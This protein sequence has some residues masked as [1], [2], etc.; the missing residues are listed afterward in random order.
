M[1]TSRLNFAVKRSLQSAGIHMLL[2][3]SRF[4]PD[5]TAATNN[6]SRHSPLRLLNVMSIDAC[7]LWKIQ[8]IKIRQP[9]CFK[10]HKKAW[11]ANAAG[12][13]LFFFTFSLIVSIQTFHRVACVRIIAAWLINS[14]SDRDRWRCGL[15]VYLKWQSKWY[16]RVNYEASKQL[17]D[18]IF[19]RESPEISEIIYFHWPLNLIWCSHRQRK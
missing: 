9:K 4:P 19:E 5:R 2:E 8:E 14:D 7:Y 15:G 6:R 13:R 11:M 17:F 1:I 16:S 3:D 18:T 12:W 10:A